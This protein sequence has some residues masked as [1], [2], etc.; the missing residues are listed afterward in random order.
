MVDFQTNPIFANLNQGP[1]TIKTRDAGGCERDTTI[2]LWYQVRPSYFSSF[3][4][5]PDNMR[6]QKWKYQCKSCAGNQSFDITVALSFTVR[7]QALSASSEHGHWL[8]PGFIIFIIRMAAVLI[9]LS[10]L[11]AFYNERP[12]RLTVEIVDQKCNIDDGSIRISTSG[13]SATLIS[14]I[15]TA[16]AMAPTQI[17]TA[18]APGNYANQCKDKNTCTFDTVAIVKP[19]ILSPSTRS[20]DKNRIRPALSLMAELG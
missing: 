3:T 9:P 12:K 20:V 14:L 10:E 1:H 17:N 15:L 13:A 18:L 11:M 8:L 4:T 2:Y 7:K 6:Q 19:Y 16:A 5:T